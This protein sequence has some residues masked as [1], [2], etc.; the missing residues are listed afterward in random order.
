MAAFRKKAR[1]NTISTVPYKFPSLR[2]LRQNSE[3]DVFVFG[4]LF[5]LKHSSLFPEGCL[6]FSIPKL[7]QS[8]SGQAWVPSLATPV[9]NFL[10]LGITLKGPASSFLTNSLE[11]FQQL[12]GV[13][14]IAFSISSPAPPTA[15]LLNLTF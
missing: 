12:V 6:L 9:H 14:Q 4:L 7:E 1:A 13:G 2:H 15:V 5:L 10:T 8:S 3:L 11:E